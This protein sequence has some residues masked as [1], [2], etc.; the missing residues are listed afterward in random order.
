M[1]AVIRKE[2][3]KEK[4]VIK[5]LSQRRRRLLPDSCYEGAYGDPIIN[6]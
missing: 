4:R 2:Y 1:K 5:K 3:Q 6:T